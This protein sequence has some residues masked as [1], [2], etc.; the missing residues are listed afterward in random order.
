MYVVVNKMKPLPS[1][2]NIFVRYK[3]LAGRL[4]GL[5]T[6]AFPFFTLRALFSG[7]TPVVGAGSFREWGAPSQAVPALEIKHSCLAYFESETARERYITLG[8]VDER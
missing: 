8:L 3:F 2:E 5:P 6:D 1:S 7:K 4:F